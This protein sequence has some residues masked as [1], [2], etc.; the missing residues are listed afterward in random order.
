MAG[1]DA[2]IL[3]PSGTPEATKHNHLETTA[4]LTL[5]T[6]HLDY[7]K[8][9]DIADWVNRPA[10]VRRKETKRR[11]GRI[12][13]P[14]NSF[15][16]YRSTMKTAGVLSF[17]NKQQVISAIVAE[18]WRNEPQEVRE[19]YKEYARIEN[20]NHHNAYPQYKF[21]PK[22]STIEGRKKANT[23]TKGEAL[24]TLSGDDLCSSHY[25]SGLALEAELSAY[26]PSCHS[27]T[28]DSMWSHIPESSIF[29]PLYPMGS[30]LLPAQIGHCAVSSNTAP[31]ANLYSYE[32]RFIPSSPP[33]SPMDATWE[34]F[35][36]G[37]GFNISDPCTLHH[38]VYPHE[39]GVMYHSLESLLP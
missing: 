32:Q 21:S 36:D 27:D 39:S 7:T 25:Q 1:T 4:R 5:S 20:E 37:T 22:K 17:T 33:F 15:M 26:T 30:I 16:L 29:E 2:R 34:L 8:V 19:L 38:H 28:N 11:H 6:T 23:R 35:T 10:N 14:L 13:R 9:K 24:A 31:T 12:A 18:S 3:L